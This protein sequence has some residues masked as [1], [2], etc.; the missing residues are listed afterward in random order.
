MRPTVCSTSRDPLRRSSVAVIWLSTLQHRYCS[1]CFVIAGS[2]YRERYECGITA[3]DQSIVRQQVV[4]KPPSPEHNN[5]GSQHASNP[6]PQMLLYYIS[7]L[8]SNN[9]RL[10][11][12][13]ITRLWSCKPSYKFRRSGALIA[14][15][16]RWTAALAPGV[17]LAPSAI[18][19]SRLAA[20]VSVCA[21]PVSACMSV[22]SVGL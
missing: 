3:L 17:G 7:P 13:T 5:C 22:C 10:S 8:L 1:V 6:K 11:Y 21:L 20:R 12:A 9:V 18:C 19:S 16:E 2:W 14:L 4:Y 15:V